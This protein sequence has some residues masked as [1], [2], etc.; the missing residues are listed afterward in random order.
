MLKT[1]VRRIQANS[2]LNWAKAKKEKRGGGGEKERERLT[3]E[4]IEPSCL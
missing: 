1:A 3:A 4:E 2:P